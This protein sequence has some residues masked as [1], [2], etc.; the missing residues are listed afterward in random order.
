MLAWLGRAI[1]RF[2]R[3]V[4]AAIL[5]RRF[6]TPSCCRRMCDK[7]RLAA[8]GKRKEGTAYRPAELFHFKRRFDRGANDGH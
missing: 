5:G 4:R 6:N 3:I 7:G 2:T 1:V 8:T